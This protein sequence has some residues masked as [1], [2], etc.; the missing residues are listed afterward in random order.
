[1]VPQRQGRLDRREDNEW[2]IATLIEEEK[3]LKQGECLY[4]KLAVS[5]LL[6]DIDSQWQEWE[7]QG[8]LTKICLW[9]LWCPI[10]FWRY[11]AQGSLHSGVILTIWFARCLSTCELITLRS[12][13]S[14]WREIHTCIGNNLDWFSDSQIWM[15]WVWFLF[16]FFPVTEKETLSN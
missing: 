16:Y 4:W 12:F 6:S 5:S 7:A 3:E 11:S 15:R 9:Y 2:E 13:H 10:W 1:M 8:D 14:Q